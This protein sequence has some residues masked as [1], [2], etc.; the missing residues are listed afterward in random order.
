MV[1]YESD[2]HKMLPSRKYFLKK[3]C[4]FFFLIFFVKSITW[5]NLAHSRIKNK[6][7]SLLLNL[8]HFLL[9]L[10]HFYLYQGPPIMSSSFSLFFFLYLHLHSPSNF[11]LF[12]SNPSIFPFLTSILFSSSTFISI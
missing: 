1:I 8:Y 11:S 5:K 9:L 10:P 4:F 7:F 2:P 3:L 6:L 12:T